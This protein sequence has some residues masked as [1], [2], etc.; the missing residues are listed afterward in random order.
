LGVGSK[1]PHI[2]LQFDVDINCIMGVSVV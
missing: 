2:F 1:S